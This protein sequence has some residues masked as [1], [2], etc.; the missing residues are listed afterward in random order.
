MI[1]ILSCVQLSVVP[2]L[3]FRLNFTKAKLPL[4]P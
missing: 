3:K 4:L 2:P 1:I